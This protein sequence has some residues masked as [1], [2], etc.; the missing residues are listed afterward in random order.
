MILSLMKAFGM[1]GAPDE[2]RLYTRQIDLSGNVFRFEIPEDFSQDMPA[3]DL[4]EQLDIQNSANL[5]RNGY[6]TLMRR[7]WDI[8]KPGFRGKQMGTIMMSITVRARP[9]NRAG[10]LRAKPYD[11]HIMLHFV[12]ALYDSLDQR[13]RDHNNEVTLSGNPELSVYVPELVTKIGETVYPN[14]KDLS[15]NKKNKWVST[16]I[17]VSETGQINKLYAIP[18]DQDNFLEIEFSLMPNDDVVAR[19]FVDLAMVRV[20]KIVETF[21][22]KYAKSNEFDRV[23][24]EDWMDKTVLGE[25]ESNSNKNPDGLLIWH[26]LFYPQAIGRLK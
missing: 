22:L 26:G 15:L 3:E 14:F 6:V 17:G 5:Q 24:G 7:W 9:E 25:L 12:V 21:D 8:K 1:S 2:L 19:E 20:N 10:I 16:G 13:Y 4:I 11:F 18:L 23:T